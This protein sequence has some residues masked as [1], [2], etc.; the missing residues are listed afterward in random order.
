[1]PAI[2]TGLRTQVDYAAGELAPLSTQV[3]VL[4]FEFTDGILR[5]NDNREIDVS[6]IE[7]LTI[8]V[9]RSLICERTSDL[10]VAPTE[11]VLTDGRTTRPA[12]SNCPR[13]NRD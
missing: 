11:R 7:G 6:D 1:M 13:R 2:C 10:V 12:L 4:D 3:T 8:K 5:R 9:L